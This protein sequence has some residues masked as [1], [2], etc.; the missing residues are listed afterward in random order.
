MY[1]ALSVLLYIN[2]IQALKYFE[3][4]VINQEKKNQN[5]ST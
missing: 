3:S 1:F 4:D 2:T 5:I